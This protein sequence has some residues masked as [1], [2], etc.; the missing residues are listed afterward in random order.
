MISDEIERICGH[1]PA[2]FVATPAHDARASSTPTIATVCCGP[3]ST[4]PSASE[5]SPSSTGSCAP[6][7]SC[8][9][10]STAARW[11]RAPGGRL[12]VDGAMFD[13]T[14]RR[15]AEEALRRHE[16]SRPAPR[17][18]ARRACASSRPPTPP[19]A[20]ERDLHDGAQQRLVAVVLTP[21][22]RGAGAPA[23]TPGSFPR[24]P[25]E[26]ARGWPSCATWHTG[27]TR[28][29]SASTGSPPRST[30]WSPARRSPSTWRDA[31]SA[32][33]PRSRRRSTSRSPRP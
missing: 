17:S 2:N 23:P 6:T 12:W 9:G 25:S 30:A 3:S 29:C 1:P 13:V 18:C 33:R 10:C 21:G 7:A 5:P 32:R 31:A 27:S 16:S 24:P 8:A 11:C 20:I 26:L 22:A 19:G 4:R 28:P 15:A 14:E